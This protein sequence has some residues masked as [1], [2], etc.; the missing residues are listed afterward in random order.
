MSWA[1]SRLDEA[2][3]Y[4]TVAV[5]SLLLTQDKR[6]I[7][8]RSLGLR[9]GSA[10]ENVQTKTQSVP[11]NQPSNSEDLFI[12]NTRWSKYAL[13]FQKANHKPEQKIRRHLRQNFLV[14]WCIVYQSF[15]HELGPRHPC[16][17]KDGPRRAKLTLNCFLYKRRQVLEQQC[18][19]VTVHNRTQ[20][21]TILQDSI[22]HPPFP[23]IRSHC[24][25]VLSSFLQQVVAWSFLK[26][27]FLAC[28]SLW[29]VLTSALSAVNAVTYELMMHNAGRGGGEFCKHIRLHAI[30]AH[31]LAP[32]KLRR[33]DRC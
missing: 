3:I 15:L 1:L 29:R 19:P 20:R 6:E 28:S 4:C 23:K 17:P 25:F 16:V 8:R 7:L 30:N 31:M 22:P 13:L 14:G 9:T 21:R 5:G 27:G 24:R 26:P 11:L 33:D 18:Y 12:G 10:D 32:P 2:Q